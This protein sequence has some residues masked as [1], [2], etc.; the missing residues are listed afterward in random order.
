MQTSLVTSSVQAPYPSPR[1][2]KARSHAFRCTSSSG[3]NSLRW[4]LPRLFFCKLHIPRPGLE[5]PGLTHSAAPP[6][7]EQTRFAGLCPGYFSAS[8]ISL[9]PAWKG[10]VSRIPLHPLFR[11]KLA[12]LDFAPVIFLQAP[13]PSPRPGKARSHSFRCTSSSGANSLHW[14]LLRLFFCKLHIPRPGPEL[15]FQIVFVCECR[16]DL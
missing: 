8:S 10:Q 16:G 15:G 2:G 9:A 6:H 14:T 13:Y 7:P 5:R 3:A 12:S 11:S 1:P 4:T